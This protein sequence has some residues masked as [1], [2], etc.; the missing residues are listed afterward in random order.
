MIQFGTDKDIEDIIYSTNKTTAI[1]Y[2]EPNFN[3][4]KLGSILDSFDPNKGGLYQLDFDYNC[5]LNSEACDPFLT[6]NKLSK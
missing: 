5:N 1:L 4:F 3:S 6:I 2:P